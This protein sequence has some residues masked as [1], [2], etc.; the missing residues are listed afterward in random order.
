MNQITDLHRTGHAEHDGRPAI[1]VALLLP[2]SPTWQTLRRA[3]LLA[4]ELSLARSNSGQQVALTIGLPEASESRWRAGERMLQDY[5]PGIVVRHAE[6]TRIP[7]ANA[8]RMFADLPATTDLAGMEK[9]AVPRDWGWN[10]QDCDLWISLADPGIGAVLPL[11]PTLHYC[12][13]LP[14]RYVPEAVAPSIK[15][16]YWTRQVEA[17][18]LWRQ[19]LVATSD[20]DTIADLV[21]YAGVRRER[22]ELVPEVLDRLP[23]LSGDAESK[24]GELMLWHLRGT[25]LDDLRNCLEG[26]AAYYREGGTL[27]VLVVAADR[28]HWA[29]HPSYGKLPIDLQEF[30]NDLPKT[31]YHSPREFERLLPQAGALW[32]SVTAGGEADDLYDAVRAGLHFL[33]PRFGL[34]ERIV[35]RLGADAT[36]YPRDEPLGLTDALHGIERQPDRKQ[37]LLAGLNIGAATRQ[38]SFGFLLDRMLEHRHV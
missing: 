2:K 16:T 31:A 32:S 18:R 33:A 36:L 17:F 30:F 5:V 38:A 13:G 20:P 21:S 37:P 28:S 6:W 14:E 15:D 19:G 27:E 11:R 3:G 10:F 34:N 24:S 1:K 25:A 7:V 22:I 23:G 35:Q 29:Q 12:S 8:R 9:V 4:S 26:L